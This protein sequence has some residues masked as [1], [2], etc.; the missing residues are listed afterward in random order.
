[1]EVSRHLAVEAS[2]ILLQPFFPALFRSNSNPKKTQMSLFVFF[3]I[4]I[5]VIYFG[6]ARPIFLIKTLLMR[7]INKHTEI[8]FLTQQKGPKTG[9]FAHV[10]L[11]N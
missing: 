5:I 1:M 3:A 4:I 2:N 10:Y 7:M 6:H 8:I 11:S 9:Q